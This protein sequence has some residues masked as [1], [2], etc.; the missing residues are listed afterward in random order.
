MIRWQL[1]LPIVVGAAGLAACIT[2]I[3]IP[4]PLVEARQQMQPRE[5][6]TLAREDL[7][8]SIVQTPNADD[9]VTAYQRAAEAILK[10]AQNARASADEPPLITGRIPLPR[11]RPLP[12]P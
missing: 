3:A 4:T 8:P 7:V 11:R 10:R 9:G 12:R 2:H 5:P 1:A 6:R